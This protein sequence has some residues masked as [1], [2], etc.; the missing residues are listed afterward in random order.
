MGI[1]FFGPTCADSVLDGRALVERDLVVPADGADG[2]AV[3]G[4]EDG[5]VGRRRALA[6]DRVVSRGTGTSSPVAVRAQIARLAA[7]HRLFWL[8][9][10]DKRSVPVP[11]VRRRRRRG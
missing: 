10:M 9:L 3:G 5:A 4:A 11:G 8:L 7:H 1:Y 2:A 6:A